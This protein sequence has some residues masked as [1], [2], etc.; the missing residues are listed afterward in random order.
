MCLQTAT[1]DWY[2]VACILEVDAIVN[3][4]NRS[5]L[6]GGGIDGAIHAAAGHGLYQ[7]CR[8][9]GGCDTG[10]TKLTGGH[11]LPCKHILHTVGPVGENPSALKS[12]YQTCMEL[13]EKSQIRSVAF[14]CIST[15]IYGY[16]AGPAAKIALTTVRR[17]LEKHRDSVCNLNCTFYLIMSV[18]SNH[19]C[20]FLTERLGYL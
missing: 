12:C 4:A 14:C 10:H 2:S 20:M 13:A 1:L 19:F 8:T 17:Y 11:R 5:L 18:W 16:P 6:G 9:L 3:A 7:E 15:G